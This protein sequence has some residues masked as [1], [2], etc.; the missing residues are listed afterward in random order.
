MDTG[1]YE[2]R[3]KEAADRYEGQCR[4]CGACCGAF[5]D[6]CLNLFQENGKYYCRVYP[7]RLGIQKTVSGKAFNCVPIRELRK[8]ARFYPGCAYFS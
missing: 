2:A 8:L 6:P 7:E 1:N 4:H 3:Q 5:E